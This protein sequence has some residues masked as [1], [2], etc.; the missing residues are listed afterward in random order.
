M[1]T[2]LNQSTY[3]S[4]ISKQSIPKYCQSQ[5]FDSQINPEICQKHTII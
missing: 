5:N 2:T 1:S 3:Q 4:K